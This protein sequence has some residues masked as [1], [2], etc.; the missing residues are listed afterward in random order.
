MNDLPK[1]LVIPSLLISGIAGAREP[2]PQ[3]HEVEAVLDISVANQQNGSA[4]DVQY[5]FTPESLN[6]VDDVHPVLRRYVH[7]PSALWA[8]VTRFANSDAASQTA[9]DIGGIYYLAD[10]M[11]FGT[12]QVGFEIDRVNNANEDGYYS[13]PYRAEIGAR[14]APLLQISGFWEAHQIITATTDPDLVSGMAQRSG[15]EEIAGGTISWA[16]SNDR[17]FLSLSAGYHGADW[18]FTVF[19]PGTT[20]VNGAI[21]RFM[22][23]LQVSPTLSLQL[24]GEGGRDHWV[25][26][27]AFD[28]QTDWIGVNVDRIVYDASGAGDLLYW[29]KGRLAFRFSLGGG[30]QG[31]PPVYNAKNRGF[32]TVGF[33]V[34]TRF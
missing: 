12:A 28:N 32:G 26:N 13:L 10:G 11:L 31:A 24:H 5:T 1:W 3:L 6:R 18:K 7:H 30:Y 33:G 25:D 20:T 19:H 34:T 4:F 2:E 8:N 17:L 27:R 21:V 14:P 16:T 22:V 29:Y 15:N 9:A 23:A